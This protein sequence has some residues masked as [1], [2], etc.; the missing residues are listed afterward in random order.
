MLCA[1]HVLYV[2]GRD[3][4]GVRREGGLRP[5]AR[6]FR[7]G[8][9]RREQGGEGIGVRIATA[10]SHRRLVGWFPITSWK[11]GDG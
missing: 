3:E 8:L 5:G 10:S 1:T 9:H 6:P 7:H 4:R 2:T 11:M